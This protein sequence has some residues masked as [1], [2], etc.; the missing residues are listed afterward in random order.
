[1]TTLGSMDPDEAAASGAHRAE[2]NPADLATDVAPPEPEARKHA[3]D[4]RVPG[5]ATDSLWYLAARDLVPHMARNDRLHWIDGFVAACE[6]LRDLDGDPMAEM[7]RRTT[8]GEH[9]EA[10]DELLLTTDRE[11]LGRWLFKRSA[12]AYGKGDAGEGLDIVWGNP[13]VQKFWLA[14]ADAILGFFANGESIPARPGYT[15]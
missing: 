3:R 7:L 12:K 8:E 13:K 15:R 6:T 2:L 14:E 10:R 11:S 1:M 5:G 9:I 4:L